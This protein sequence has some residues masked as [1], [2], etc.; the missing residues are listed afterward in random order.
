MKYN[1][2]DNLILKTHLAKN[3]NT[4]ISVGFDLK[5][6]TLTLSGHASI[7]LLRKRIS[8]FTNGMVSNF[9][10]LNIISITVIRYLPF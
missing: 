1:T 7:F 6:K 3:N 5:Q 9:K 2:G 10:N 8:Y 4:I